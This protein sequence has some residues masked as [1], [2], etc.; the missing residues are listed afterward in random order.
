M[1]YT[2]PA[3]RR[4]TRKRRTYR[5]KTYKRKSSRKRTPIKKMIRR[6]IA[7]NTEDKVANMYNYNATLATIGTPNIENNNMFPSRPVPS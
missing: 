4:A 7:R 6:E 1:A 5:K 3:Y 2:S